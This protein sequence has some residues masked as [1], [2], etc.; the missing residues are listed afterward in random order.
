M[1]G[2][3]AYR[4]L[5]WLHPPAFRRQFADEMLWIFDEAAGTCGAASLL[6]D[7]SLSLIRQWLLRSDLWRGVVAVIG[8]SV[9][10]VVAFG[11]FIPWDSVWRAIRS[12]F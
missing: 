10:V 6:A 5:L 9:S 8:G 12:A 4:G 11:S 2:R 7:A 3:G 1:T